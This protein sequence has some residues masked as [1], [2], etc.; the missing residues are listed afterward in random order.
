VFHVASAAAIGEQVDFAVRSDR[1][2]LSA[3]PGSG[4]AGYSLLGRVAAVEYQGAA[5][6]VS[7]ST[8]LAEDFV[9]T[10]PEANFFMRPLSVGQP[11]LAS[12]APSDIHL[13]QAS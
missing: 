12:W 1:I 13:L 5:V 8:G 9:A 4:L 6:Q 2:E 11:V 7:L 3:E 10:L